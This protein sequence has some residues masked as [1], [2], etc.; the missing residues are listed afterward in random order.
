MLYELDGKRPVCD[1]AKSWVA[2][3]ASVIGDVVLEE[4]ASVWFGA[5][6][7]GDNDRIHIGR[8]SNIQDGSVLHVDPGIP[9]FIGAEVTIGHLV[10][11]H[12]CTI[13]DGSLIGIGAVVLNGAKIGAN[14]L[15][16]A[17]ALITEGKEIP[18]RS[19]VMGAPGKIVREVSDDDLLRIRRGVESYIERSRLYRDGLRPVTG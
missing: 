13:G 17:N 9:L 19:V 5:T 1:P 2:E 14:C 12:G 7:R 11:L 8:G 3:S 6:V 18:P 15:I 16:G 10:M 4:D